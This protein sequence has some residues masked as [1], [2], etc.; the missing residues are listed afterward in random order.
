LHPYPQQSSGL[1]PVGDGGE[2]PYAEFNG[3]I[4]EPIPVILIE[5]NNY[6]SEV[7]GSSLKKRLRESSF[8]A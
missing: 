3:K 5:D 8:F 4:R 2:S 6:S 7:A 1:N